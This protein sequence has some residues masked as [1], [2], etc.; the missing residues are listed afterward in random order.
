[1][2]IIVF[3]PLQ[4]LVELFIKVFQI[5]KVTQ[6]KMADRNKYVGMVISKNSGKKNLRIKDKNKID[7]IGSDF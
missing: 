2:D 1:M 6:T 4:A 5:T 7:K 3:H